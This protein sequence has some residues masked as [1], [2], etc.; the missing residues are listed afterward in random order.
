MGE[1]MIQDSDLIFNEES[2]RYYLTSNYVYDKLGTDLSKI[3]YD[4]LDTNRA[5]LVQRTIEF[6]CDELYDFIEDN[7]VSPKSALYAVTQNDEM[8]N[9]IKKALGYQLLYFIQNG[10]AS[11]EAGNV[12]SNTVSARA[13]QILKAK[14]V[15]H[16]ILTKIPEIW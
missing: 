13:I 1:I 14:G 15:F 6:A 4:E 12:M 10:D 16:I 8:H 11:Q 5:T 7:A 2:K 3:L 9:A